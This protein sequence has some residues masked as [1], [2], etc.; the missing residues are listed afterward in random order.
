[1]SIKVKAKAFKSM[2]HTDGFD[3]IAF[4]PIFPYTNAL[5]LSKYLT[6]SCKGDLSW[7]SIGKEYEL[8]IEELET[9]KY[10]TT[11]NIISCPSLTINLKDLTRSQSKEILMEFT[12]ERQAENILCAYP[13]FIY[14]VVT[15]G[16]ESI[17]IK[18]IH[19]VGEVYLN[20]YVR[21]INTRYKYF[22][23][24]ERVK[25]WGIDV[26]DC[27]KLIDAFQN[28]ELIVKA[29]KDNPYQCLI[30]VLDRSFEKADKLIM[31]LRPD[32]RHSE[33]RCSYV[34]LNVL[35][36][37]EEE[38]STRLNANIVYNYILEQYPQA[39]DIEDLIVPTVTNNTLFYYNDENKDLAIMTTYLAECRIAE[40]V[41]DKIKNSHQLNIDCEKYRTSDDG[42]TLTDDQFTLLTNFCKYDFML[43][44]GYAGSG[45]T[46]SVKNLITLMEENKITYTLL[47]STG[48]A[49]RVLSESTNRA[50]TTIHKRCFQG[51]ITSDVVIIDECGMVNL[52][53]FI[54]FLNSIDNDDMKIILVG[55]NAQLSAIGL[56]KIFD[57]LLNSDKVPK[58]MLTE[59]FRYKSNGSLFVA[60]NVRNGKTFFNDKELVKKTDDGYSIGGNYKFIE[61]ENDLIFDEVIKQYLK[62]LDKGV[63]KKDILILSPFNKGDMGTYAINNAIQAEIN[64]PKVNEP[65]HTRKLDNNTIVFRTNDIV[66]NT[67]NDY[68][69]VSQKAYLEMLEYGL[70]EE[71]VEDSVVVNG[72]IGIVRE[73]VD[74]GLIIQ[75]DEELIYV[76]KA[77]LNHLLLGYAI[78]SHKSQG[79]GSDY[80]IS[81]ISTHHKRMLSRGLLYVMDTR[82]KKACIDIGQ[83]EAFEYGLKIVDND[84]R[85][86]F[87]LDLMKES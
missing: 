18:K 52:D 15:E 36:K 68:H 32:L 31:E 56:S 55:D 34:I 7:V 3:I 24:I 13:D 80:V 82:C 66:I 77:K 17:D 43:L 70:K 35:E 12:T 40:F 42:T 87:L 71:D 78:S 20:A 67:K 2:F 48:K 1:M 11:Y 73:V 47:S 76:S 14:K 79:S 6:F 8:E 38:G 28:E 44:A 46:K 60:T 53:T 16:K 22:G 37:N 61:R 85:D 19:N 23:I 62:L 81:V 45:K 83:V 9:N 84:L 21:E 63:K 64:P 49:S 50:A 65:Y 69:A 57:D 75:Y 74:D 5:K 27:K 26:G 33:Q 30:S 59:I 58:T 39:K 41:K 51:K 4:S 10:G 72:Q 25:E 86:T 29:F 54:M